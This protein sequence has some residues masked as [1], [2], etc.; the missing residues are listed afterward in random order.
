VP[1]Q[2]MALLLERRQIVGLDSTRY[3]NAK[4]EMVD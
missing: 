2:P 1:A 3:Q 4:I